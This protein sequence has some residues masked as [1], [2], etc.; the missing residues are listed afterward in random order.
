M[1]KLFFA[2]WII[3]HVSPELGRIHP[4]SRNDIISSFPAV[5]RRVGRWCS[6]FA[7]FVFGLALS[8]YLPL[9]SPSRSLRVLSPQFNPLENVPHQ[10]DLDT[11]ASPSGVNNAE[12]RR[13]CDGPKWKHSF[14]SCEFH[15]GQGP[16]KNL[17]KENA[18][19][20]MNTLKFFF[21]FF[22][23]T[24]MIEATGSENTEMRL[25]QR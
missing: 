21:V 3:Q 13:E 9:L 5:E 2:P 16:K 7:F 14:F 24:L 25:W 8:P 11:T 19:E 12:G 20:R 1:Q 15:A 6:V 10:L 23:P 17:K 22:P 18:G 4:P